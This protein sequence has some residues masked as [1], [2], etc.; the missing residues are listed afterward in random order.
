MYNKK[1]SK[2]LLDP[3]LEVKQLDLFGRFMSGFVFVDYTKTLCIDATSLYSPP[4]RSS[5][6]KPSLDLGIGHLQVFGHLC[7]LSARKVFLRKQ[8]I[9]IRNSEPT[10]TLNTCL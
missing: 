7:A 10:T 5:V 4:F 3:S 8:S 9:V 2:T 6:L 1:I